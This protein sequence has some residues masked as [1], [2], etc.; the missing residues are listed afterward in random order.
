MGSKEMEIL[1]SYCQLDMRLV[2]L[3]QLGGHGVP[4]R[5]SLTSTQWFPYLWPPEEAPACQTICNKCQHEYVTPRLQTPD[6]DFFYAR[7]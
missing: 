6:T 1:G 2:T 7:I 4:S 3:L 5:Q